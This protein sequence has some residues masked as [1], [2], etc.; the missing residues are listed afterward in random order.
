MP[1]LLRCVLLSAFLMSGA[2]CHGMEIPGSGKRI[3]IQRTDEAPSI[4]GHIAAGEWDQAT[5]FSDLHQVE[6]VEFS[7][8]SEQTIWYIAYDSDAL[9][10]AAHAYDSDP[11]GIL[12]QML[13]QGGSLVSDDSLHI[14][15]DSFNNKRSGYAFGLNPNGV[16]QDAIFTS[17]TRSS[18]DWDGVWRGAAARTDEG[19]SMEMAIPFKTLT[20]DP[21]NTTWGI[22]FWREIVRK[23]EKI[24]WS[25][26]N[27]QINPTVSGEVYGLS[28]LS[29]G[30][31]LDVIPSV[32][33]TYRKNREL[34]TSE[35][36]QKPSLDVSYKLTPSINMLLTINTDFGH[37]HNLY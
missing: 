8:P 14:M 12:A 33:S 19:W 34:N 30:I 25:S 27:G 7:E 22:N 3:L 18:D 37:Y 10:V 32:S 35:S 6:P 24:A 4:D 17:A 29:Q 21:D 28:E 31:G 36:E 9:Y 16:R 13:R 1:T 5:T 15:V 23:N 11:D 20:F 26:R 2:F